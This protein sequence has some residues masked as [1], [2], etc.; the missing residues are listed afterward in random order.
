[1]SGWVYTDVTIH[2]E[3]TNSVHAASGVYLFNQRTRD[4]FIL[5]VSNVP[6][7]S[8]HQALFSSKEMVAK[9]EVKWIPLILQELIP[10]KQGGKVGGFTEFIQGLVDYDGFEFIPNNNQDLCLLT[11]KLGIALINPMDPFL[12]E[13]HLLPLTLKDASEVE[14]PC[15]IKISCCPF[16]LTNVALF[17]NYKN[18]GSVNYKIGKNSGFLSDCRYM[19]DMGGG[20][21]ECEG[22]QGESIGIVAGCLKKLNGDGALLAIISWNTITKLLN[23]PEFKLS[24]KHQSLQSLQTSA[25]SSTSGLKDDLIYSVVKISI[26]TKNKGNFWGSGVV[27]SSQYIIT[28]DHVLKREELAELK[29]ETTKG[30][31]HEFSL[32]DVELI[33]CPILGYDLCFLKLRSPS[34][35]LKPAKICKSYKAQLESLQIGKPVKSVGYGLIY[36]HDAESSVPFHSEGF[37]NTL[38]PLTLNDYGYQEP[39]LIIASAGCWNGSSGG[40]LFSEVGELIG[41]MTSNGKLTTGEILPNFTLVVPIT[42]IEKSLFMIENELPQ[43]DLKQKVSDLWMLKNTSLNRVITKLTSKL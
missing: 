43:V 12:K 10:I 30:S 4:Y 32:S 31:G 42:V 39:A 21:V 24:R 23:N 25:L 36:S 9:S 26:T 19:D 6:N 13:D 18:H 20:I 29:I 40:G 22:S 16:S 41:V 15:K 35:F 11:Y 37:I 14:V 34:Q 5:T 8:L 17:I 28:N 3:A 1:M 38:V 27:L 7:L 33:S 2:F